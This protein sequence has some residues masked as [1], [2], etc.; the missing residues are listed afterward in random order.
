MELPRRDRHI[1]PNVATT[2]TDPLNMLH[3]QFTGGL[4]PLLEAVS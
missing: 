2:M 3:R 1:H 4:F